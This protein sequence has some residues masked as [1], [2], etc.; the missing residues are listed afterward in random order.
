MNRDYYIDEDFIR[1]IDYIATHKEFLKT[2][3]ITHHGITRYDHCMRVAYYSYKVTKFLKLDYKKTAEAALLHDFFLDE[4]D[5]EN[6]IAK[7]RHH[8]DCA[9]SNSL[10]YFDL[11]DKQIDII[12]TH[13]FPVTFTPPKY[14]ESWIVDIV[15][16]LSAIYE[17]CYITRYQLKSATTFLLILLLNILK[18]R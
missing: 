11:D 16:D 6:G 1:I 13:M 7:L 5:S 8:P 18:I 14:L 9:V 10:K 4:V 3:D 17:R 2:K 15:D 12:K